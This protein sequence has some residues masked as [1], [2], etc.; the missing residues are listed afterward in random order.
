MP[1]RSYPKILALA[2]SEQSGI[3]PG[4]IDFFD[5]AEFDFFI[6]MVNQIGDELMLIDGEGCIVFVNDATVRGLGYRR[7]DLLNQPV[8]KFFK[9]KMSLSQW[10]RKHFSLLK[11]DP[12]PN[13]FQVERVVKGG[14]IQTIEVTAV[15]M[16]YEGQEYVLSVA[17]D[18]TKQLALQQQ[19]KEMADF[20]H[21]L[22]EEAG[23]PILIIDRGGL[24]TYV[25]RA[26]EHFLRLPAKR[27]VGKSLE[28]FVNADS[29]AALK[30][31]SS[32]VEQ[33][34]TK[35]ALAIDFLDVKGNPL[36]AELTISPIKKEGKVVSS[37]IIARDLS[38]RRE[39]EQLMI[40][41]EKMQAVQYFV[42]GTAQE[43]KHPLL[44]VMKR[45][46]ALLKKYQNRDFEYI[47]FKEFKDIISVLETINKQIK[48]CF[49]TTVRL[50]E[51][52]R[53]KGKIVN[54]NC[55]VPAVLGDILKLRM[56]EL[57]ARQITLKYRV[58]EKLPV[59]DMGQIE[60]NQIMTS[61]I[62]N[63]IEAMPGGGILSILGSFLKASQQVQ[64]EV[65]DEGVGV[66]P[67]ILPH[68]FEPFY[69][70]KQRG[71]EKHTG[72]GLTIVYSLMTAHNGKIQIQSNR[73][74]GTMIKLLFPTQKGHARP[75]GPDCSDDGSSFLS[76]E[77]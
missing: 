63:A 22:S 43:L 17:R 49:D 65:K 30:G 13:S 4:P 59:I 29:V 18:I 12:R 71:V 76:S 55:Y 16:V 34:G 77:R 66:D 64:I 54:E 62:N 23:D 52:N 1:I 15:L 50:E 44:G 2:S 39:I 53:R 45:S 47:G 25:N 58:P 6:K 67:D 74:Q 37:H 33:S 41:S 70:T 7:E 19:L 11:R 3:T 32:R 68:V 73:S 57:R 31:F 21:L 75:R 24:I 27:L 46:Q 8:M 42:T 56:T 48:Y 35:F 20:Y 5:R 10:K 14:D 60:F 26:A 61:L 38:S 51:L 40:E 69:T 36:P 28:N 9:N 72:L